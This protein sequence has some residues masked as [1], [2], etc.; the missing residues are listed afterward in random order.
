MGYRAYVLNQ[1]LSDVCQQGEAHFLDITGTLEPELMAHDGYH[2]NEKGA[3]L[4]AESISQQVIPFIS[5][6]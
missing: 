4:W 5:K 1:V 3:E 6:Q 2:P